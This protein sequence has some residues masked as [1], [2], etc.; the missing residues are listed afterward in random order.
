MLV[1]SGFKFVVSES[2]RAFLILCSCLCH[3]NFVSLHLLCFLL[4]DL[5]LS[6]RGEGGGGEGKSWGCDEETGSER[7]LWPI[8]NIHTQLITFNRDLS[9]L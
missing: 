2:C 3:C 8:Q 6:H 9:G 7:N 4:P 1:A 5:C